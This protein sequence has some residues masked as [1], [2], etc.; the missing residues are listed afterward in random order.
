[1]PSA[2]VPAISVHGANRLRGNSCSTCSCSARAASRLYARLLRDSRIRV[3]LPDDAADASPRPG[4][5][6]GNRAANCVPAIADDLRRTMQAHC[7]VFPHRRFPAPWAC[8]A[9]CARNRPPGA[10]RPRD[11]SRIFNTTRIE[12]AG[13]GNLVRCRARRAGLGHPSHQK[14]PARDFP[15]RDDE[16]GIRHRAVRVRKTRSTPNP[17]G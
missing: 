3:P 14:P 8:A 1:M 6:W 5:R 4:W 7:S 2:N 15:E 16:R 9:R 13:T 10:C 17:C 12:G 11:T